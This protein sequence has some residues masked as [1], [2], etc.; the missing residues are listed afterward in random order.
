M[1]EDQLQGK[2]HETKKQ[3]YTVLD[4]IIEKEIPKEHENQNVQQ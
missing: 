4:E 1:Y 2:K 3:E